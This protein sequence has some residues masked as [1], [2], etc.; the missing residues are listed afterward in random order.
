MKALNYTMSK[1]VSAAAAALMRYDTPRLVCVHPLP[2]KD[3][4]TD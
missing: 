1:G 2:F 4:T 3:N